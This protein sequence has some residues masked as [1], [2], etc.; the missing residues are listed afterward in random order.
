MENKIALISVSRKDGLD[1]FARILVN[2][3]FTIIGTSGTAS[4]LAS[5]GLPCTLIEDFT[6]A[7]EI[8]DGRVKT[9]HPKIHGGV[10]ARRDSPE[11]RSQLAQLEIPFIDIVVVNL[12]PFV[13]SLADF[14]AKGRVPTLEE[15]K[16]FVDIG[17]PTLLRAAA[18][19]ALGVLPL[20]DPDDYDQ[21][22]AFLA[23][24]LEVPR[25]LRLEL[26]KKVFTFT[27]AYDLEISRF[28]GSLAADSSRGDDNL[29]SVL[30]AERANPDIEGF[31][32]VLKQ[33]LRYGENPHQS[34][35]LYSPF[36][37]SVGRDTKS[38]SWQVLQGKE[39][40]YNNFLDFD[41]TVRLL[42]VL[43]EDRPSCVIIKHLNPCGAAVAA[44][45]I[46]SL[47]LA[48]KGDPRS[49]FGGIVGFRGEVDL[50][51]AKNVR[52]D[53]AEILVAPA[54]TEEA[55]VE[56]AGSKNLRVVK[57]A[58]NFLGQ[59][60]AAKDMRFVA[61]DILVQESDNLTYLDAE[62]EVSRAELV[63]SLQLTSKQQSDLV[64]AWGLCAR[65]SSNAI[66]LVKDQMLIGAGAGQMSRI[67][68]VELALS[69]A[70]KHRHTLDGCVAA[71]DAFFPFPDS[72]EE[73]AA[74]GVKAI[75]APR[76]ARRDSEVR[77]LAESLGVSLL[78][79]ERRH[80]RH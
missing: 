33:G 39:L 78:F 32:G 63:T 62:D 15:M 31:V 64:L 35:A 76:G 69:R 16:E 79:A 17:G 65:V 5:F 67:D 56:L 27:A 10:L 11:H 44:T 8:L 47:L 57:L 40:S 23:E 58:P 37:A 55:L 9:L 59:T 34:A 18:K 14:A 1:R 49:H 54:F 50:E 73:L 42:R 3:G 51:V 20:I 72:V 53:F 74:N 13:D 77:D 28:L 38:N 45:A 80:F 41:A 30:G 21:V 12:Y 2:A 48:K 60:G 19:N 24:G 61:G 4:F 70:K 36:T 22:G 46:E 29:G 71:S 66:V 25:E 68:S 26:A 6:G 7:P 43:P 52:E 75:I